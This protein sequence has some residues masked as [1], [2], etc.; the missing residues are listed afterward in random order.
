M[1]ENRTFE[2][3][4]INT[5]TFDLVVLSIME[6][7]RRRLSPDAYNDEI[8]PEEEFCEYIDDDLTA[9][10]SDSLSCHSSGSDSDSSTT[11]DSHSG[12]SSSSDKHTNNPAMDE[13]AGIDGINISAV[14]DGVRNQMYGHRGVRRGPRTRGGRS[15]GVHDRL[16][17][18]VESRRREQ[19]RLEALWVTEDNDP[20]LHPFTGNAGLQVE[21]DHNIATA[22]DYNDLFLTDAIILFISAQVNLYASQFIAMNPNHV[23]SKQWTDATPD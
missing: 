21:M 16:I 17:S 22:L 6:S 3:T 14:L 15:R 19:E 11:T 13:H 20:T 5:M 23:W 4:T 7:K 12:D 8:D 2:N 18:K 9:S 10:D 1:N